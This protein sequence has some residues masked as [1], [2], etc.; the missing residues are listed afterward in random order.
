MT[1]AAIFDLDDTL[2][3]ERQYNVSGFRAVGAHLRAERGIEGFAETCL[4]LFER[5]VRADMFEHAARAL[6]VQVDVAELV[7][8][9]REHRPALTL[10]ADA[11]EVLGRVRGRYPLGLLT[12]GYGGVQRIK[13]AAL[14]IEPLFDSVV[15]SDDL[16][17]AAWKPSPEPY[18][19]TMR[20][21]DGR[22]D[23]F[24]YVADN[25]TK[26]FVAARR[27]G[28]RT[29]EVCRPDQPR[30][31]VTWSSEFEAELTVASLLDLPWEALERRP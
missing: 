2:Y 31:P 18:L 11:R 15:Y 26:D 25:P 27:L 1:L 20:N 16:G 19:R 22:A 3:H 14:G 10:F 30:R 7:K 28:W 23:R 24:V 21:L 12:D 9:Y 13:V 4:D 5:G 8:V 29:V 17:R 6:G